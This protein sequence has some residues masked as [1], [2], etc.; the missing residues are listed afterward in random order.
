[1]KNLIVLAILCAITAGI[2]WYLHRAKARGETC[3]GCP[4]AKNCK[5][6]ASCPSCGTNGKSEEKN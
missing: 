3:I 6:G 2:L 1:M 5:K 4:L